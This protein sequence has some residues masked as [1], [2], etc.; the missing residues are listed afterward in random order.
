MS[1]TRWYAIALIAIIAVSAVTVWWFFVPKTPILPGVELRIIT[2]HDPTLQMRI[3]QDFLASEYATNNSIT[4]I[5]AAALFMCSPLL[6]CNSRN[7]Y[8]QL[9]DTCICDTVQARALGGDHKEL[10]KK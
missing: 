3:E 5:A 4:S 7:S 1:R 8:F 6:I 2:R 10:G 9:V